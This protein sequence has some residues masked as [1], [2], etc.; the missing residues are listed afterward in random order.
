VDNGY[1]YVADGENGLRIIDIAN[2]AAPLAVDGFDTPAN[3]TSVDV[4]SY[5]VYVA[6]EY[7][8]LRIFNL[9][10][11]SQTHLQIQLQSLTNLGTVLET[12][13]VANYTSPTDRWE[14][15]GG[16][17]KM[18]PTAARG[19]L[20]IINQA[21]DLVTYVD[22]LYL[23]P[24]QQPPPAPYPLHATDGDA[25]NSLQPALKW[26]DVATAIGYRLQVA[27]DSHFQARLIDT[28]TPSPFYTVAEGLAYNHLYYWR[29]KAV[30]GAGESDWSPAW[31][32]IPRS[33][34]NYY[35]DEFE[36][37]LNPAWSWIR[38][39][40]DEWRVS[41]V[42]GALNIDLQPGD[43][44][45]GNNARNL[46]LRDTPP[47]DFEASTA[48]WPL[49]FN[50]QQAGLLIYQD[51][52]NYLS[53][54]QSYN[55]GYQIEFRAEIDGVFVEQATRPMFALLPLKIVR[56]GHRYQGYYSVDMLTWQ[57]LGRPI[58]VAWSPVRM[59]LA[60]FDPASNQPATAQFQWFRVTTPPQESH[61][62]FLPIIHAAMD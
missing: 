10:P 5:F 2:P 40:P 23:R 22:D 59:G 43:L 33:E 32:F 35:S 28:T 8:G 21:S 60:A 49:N 47:G 56:A 62:L 34:P 18:A 16:S 17:A 42:P 30:N 20:L 55:D 19:R 48:T 41:N 26:S 58:E 57:P 45:Q 14:H 37:R 54:M 38:E 53:L 7:Q 44:Q 9:K 36:G 52:D 11:A 46:L 27:A 1:A 50:Q 4:D 51:D 61:T 15:F 29:V 25:V 31:R 3:A 39:E 24:A 12:F 13:E 6:D